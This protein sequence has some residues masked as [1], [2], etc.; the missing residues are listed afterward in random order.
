M[1]HFLH[2]F[3][4]CVMFDQVI[5]VDELD[6]CPFGRFQPSIPCGS[7]PFV[8]LV[9]QTERMN[10]NITFDDS[11]ASVG[12]AVIDEYDLDVFICLRDDVFNACFQKMLRVIYR[13]DD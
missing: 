4:D 5:C 10:V 1:F 9:D 12:G 11:F 13:Y 3:I 8:F 6:I 2:V 7:G